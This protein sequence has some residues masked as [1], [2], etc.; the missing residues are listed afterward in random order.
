[1]SG[2]NIMPITG[3]VN[4][5]LGEKGWKSS[6][7]HD[8]EIIEPGYHSVFLDRYKTQVEYTSTDRVALYRLS[9]RE[10]ARANLLASAA[11]QRTVHRRLGR[12]PF[13]DQDRERVSRLLRSLRVAALLRRGPLH[14]L[15]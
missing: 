7:S 15:A 4:P 9:Y 1:M 6:F 5:N 12:G 14:G 8:M 3:A 11:A 2:V 13:G 10:A